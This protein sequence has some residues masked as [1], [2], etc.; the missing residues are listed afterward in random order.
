MPDSPR[1]ARRHARR[2]TVTPAVLAS[3]VLTVLATVLTVP[4]SAAPAPRAPSVQG[5][6]PRSGPVPAATTGFIGGEFVPADAVAP[7]TRPVLDAATYAALK[8]AA[9][10]APGGTTSTGPT[11]LA[12]PTTIGQNFPG[13]NEATACQCAPPD[14]HGA[15]GQNHYV[16]IVNSRIVVYGRSS[17]AP[18]QQASLN[19][20]FQYTGAKSSLVFDPR[21]IWDAQ[22]RRFVVSA[23]ASPEFP[24][25][26]QYFF[27]GVSKTANATGAWWIYRILVNSD[28]SVF[29]DYPQLS[30]DRRA[31]VVTAN[32]FGSGNVG[33]PYF[34]RKS[35]LYNG[36]P[37]RFWFFPQLS[38]NTLTP[39]MVLDANPTTYV[40]G[41]PT[42]G[43]RIVK[44]GF[45]NTSGR[46][47]LSVQATIPVPTFT[48]PPPA[49][50]PGTSATLD[51]L[52]SRFVNSGTQLGDRVWNVHSIAQGNSAQPRWYEFDTSNNTVVTS[53][54]FVASIT[55]DDWNASLAVN[56]A[57]EIFVTWSSTD[58]TTGVRAQMRVSGKQPTDP[59]IL[60][61]QATFTS[62]SV[63]NAGNPGRWGDY[64]AVTLDPVAGSCG[65][66][67]RV[68]ATNETVTG[69]RW[70]THITQF[71]YC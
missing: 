43:N 22:A 2:P 6:E 34:F 37:F 29:F 18:L 38:P 54:F 4:A 24:S 56:G 36:Q 53:G 7:D 35:A 19:S 13:T 33:T 70:S 63:Y 45:T 15:I 58:A 64:S 65:A 20:F 21:A 55:S 26:D 1:P 11:P 28:P 50:Q 71:G 66:N 41:V 68:W 5:T 59:A 44:Y 27:L 39:N 60:G 16:Q 52:D 9:A 69:G 8:A 49:R 57:R 12:P 40:M 48:V 67:R 42:A 14:T 25:G 23:E 62:G 47:V 61:G 31:V 46:P 30:L 51:T 32:V 10:R 17:P 3:I